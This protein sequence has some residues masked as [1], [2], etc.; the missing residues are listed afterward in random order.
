MDKKIVGFAIMFLS[1][2]FL[3]GFNIIGWRYVGDLALMWPMVWMITAVIGFILV[4]I[5]AKKSK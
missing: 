2:I 5:N 3:I 1:L 4:V